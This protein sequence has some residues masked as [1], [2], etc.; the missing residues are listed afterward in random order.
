MINIKR[1][2]FAF[3]MALVLPLSTT[4][5]SW[6][7]ANKDDVKS[8]VQTVDQ[9]AQNLCGIFY[10]DKLQLNV[11]DAIKTYCDTRDKYAPW[12]DQVLAGAKTGGEAKLTPVSK[13]VDVVVVP[14]QTPAPTPAPAPLSPVTVPE[15]AVAPTPAPTVTPAPTPV[16]APAKG[17]K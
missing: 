15:A 3:L 12:I 2:F 10:G 16:S 1:M 17:K 7:S 4:S 6:W 5:C 8:V 14:A 9:I 11:T 13:T